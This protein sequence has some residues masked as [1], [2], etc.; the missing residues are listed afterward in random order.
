MMT[1]PWL[2]GVF[3]VLP[4]W[5][6]PTVTEAQVPQF[7]QTP[8]AL[9]TALRSLDVNTR[10]NAASGLARFKKSDQAFNALHKAILQDPDVTVRQNIAQS[11]AKLGNKAKPVLAQVGV[12][13]PD[14]ATREGL[15]AYAR[16]ASIRCDILDTAMGVSDPIP[17]TEA[18]LIEYL[19]HPV[20]ATRKEAIKAIKKFKS[21]KGFQKI[22]NMATQDPVWTIRVFALRD[23]CEIYKMKA[24]PVIQHILTADPDARVRAEGLRQV[25]A[26]KA[27]QGEKLI[28][29]S[30]RVEQIPEVKQAA[31]Q[32]LGALGTRNAVHELASLAQSMPDEDSR[33]MVVEVL[34]SVKGYES[35]AKQIIGALL[36]NDSSGKVRAA[37]LKLLAADNSD[38]ACRSRAQSISDPHPS[39]RKALIAQLASCNAEIARPALEKAVTTDA[40]AEVRKEAADLLVKMGPDKS[41]ATLA[42]VLKS[43][44]SPD[45][46]RVALTALLGLPPEVQHK[47][48][49]DALREDTDVDL[50]RLAVRGLARLSA[51][52]SVP[53]LAY[54]LGH[55]TDDEVR[56]EAARALSRYSDALGY[57]AL[58]K[59]SQSDA[60]PEVRKAA[61]AGSAKSPAQTAYVDALLPQTIDPA[62]EI[63]LKAVVELC[64]LKVP[65]TFRALVRALWMDPSVEVRTAVARGFADIDHPL[66]DVGLVVAHDTDPDAGLVRTVEQ[67]QAKRV[68]RQ[69]EVLGRTKAAEPGTRLEALESLAPSPFKTVRETLERLAL[70][71]EDAG[72]RLRAARELFSYS[73][74]QALKKLLEASQKE[75]DSKTR[76]E[77]VRM[78]NTLR[79]SWLAA[80]K[81]LDL[82]ALMT[83]LQNGP[84]KERI[85]AAQDL[86]P[87]RARQAFQGLQAAAASADPALRYEAVLALAIFGDQAAVATALNN[88]KDEATKQRLV[89]LNF[90]RS[91][92]PD[93]VVAAL[94]AEKT[95]ETMLGVQAATIKPNKAYVPWLVRVA[96]SHVDKQVRLAAVRSLVLQE[97]PL[98]QWSIRVAASHDASKKTRAVIWRWAVLADARS[99]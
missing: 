81:T 30:A 47:P 22:W 4:L 71:D 97:H 79:Q 10:R 74:R 43:D 51:S 54:A 86:G 63:R 7:E 16:K 82:V 17:T 57:E 62:P 80:R 68:E 9:L 55:D 20:P 27:P 94:S 96:I 87:L 33:A 31:F 5:V 65:R 50:R 26:I 60:S 18:Q 66:V 48:V 53:A 35:Y 49:S 69:N 11:L 95:E 83:K 24:F 99:Q 42:A 32:A 45:V 19:D 13:D 28:A 92:P 29:T 76:A 61:L 14:Q 72:V 90:L 1:P 12:C 39:V 88:E 78:Y 58:T 21:T 3:L 98:A 75:T 56:L 38:A 67:T 64:Q 85:K 37:A 40:D 89:Q 46:R 93:K 91:A 25:A 36:K 77:L 84:R 52:M 44:A 41:Q 23:I 59:A 70:E 6:L 73:D 8:Y 15:A 2:R 34:A